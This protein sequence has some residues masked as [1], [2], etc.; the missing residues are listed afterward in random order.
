M[1]GSLISREESIMAKRKKSNQRAFSFEEFKKEFYTKDRKKSSR[2]N[3][4]L[5][6]FGVKMARESLAE[7]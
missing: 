2:N 3:S 1:L 7:S 6:E 5:Y 4:R